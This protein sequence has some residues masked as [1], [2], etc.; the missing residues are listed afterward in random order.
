M[1]HGVIKYHSELKGGPPALPKPTPKEPS[2]V[3]NS[4]AVKTDLPAATSTTGATAPAPAP[5]SATK[6]INN[7]YARVKN[8]YAKKVPSSSATNPYAAVKNPA[9]TETR[10]VAAKSLPANSGNMLWVD[11]YKPK[12]SSEILGNQDSVRKLQNWLLCWESLFNKDSVVGKSFSNPKGPWKAVLLSGPPGI[13]SELIDDRGF[14]SNSNRTSF[15]HS[16]AF[17]Q[18]P[19]RLR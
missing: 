1:L 10:K 14:L 4:V 13:G 3:K 11:K 19:P 16:F 7:P 8:P 2:N 6:V 18:K 9:E 12:S 5:V 17:G 15:S